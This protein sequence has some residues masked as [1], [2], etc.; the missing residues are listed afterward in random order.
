MK[1]S[2]QKELISVK[3]ND[4]ISGSTGEDMENSTIPE[5]KPGI[6]ISVLILLIGISLLAGGLYLYLSTNIMYDTAAGSIASGIA[7][8]VMIMGAIFLI[9]LSVMLLRRAKGKNA[10]S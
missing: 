2:L 6:L 3:N 5:N 8:I 1:L 4:Q 9:I 7:S 10:G